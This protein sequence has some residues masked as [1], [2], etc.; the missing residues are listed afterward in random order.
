MVIRRP[1]VS[2]APILRREP[3]TGVDWVHEI[4]WDGWRVQ[5]HKHTGGV[6]LYSRPGNDITRRFPYIADAIAAL[7]RRTIVLDG[8]LVAFDDAGHPDFHLLRRKRVPIVAFL[9]DIMECHGADL[10]G[11]R[12]RERRRYLERLMQRNRSDDLRIS[13][14]GKTA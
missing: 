11:K 10:C 7:P 5:A 3:P 2:C 1:M 13:E 14:V 8:E 12:W 6:T 4:K 9:F